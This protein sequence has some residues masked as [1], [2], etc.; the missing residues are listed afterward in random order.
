MA[1]IQHSTLPSSAVHEPKHITINGISSSGKVITNSSSTSGQSEYRRLVSNDIEE[2]EV[3]VQAE[4]LGATGAFEY[5]I[6]SVFAGSI[7]QISAIVN[8][9]VAG[10]SNAYKM[11]I[12]GVDVTG[13]ALTVDT[14]IGTGGEA[15]DIVTATPTGANTFTSDVPLTLVSTSVGN[16]ESALD[17]RFVITLRRG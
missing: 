16:T 9:A 10:A 1:N 8:T 11:Q 3:L 13:S 17:V 7:Q 14:S 6:P 15:G 5:Y 2:L 12:D 4:H